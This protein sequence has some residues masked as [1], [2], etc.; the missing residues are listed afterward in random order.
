[1]LNRPWWVGT[2]V[3]PAGASK[4]RRGPGV[5]SSLPVR[6]APVAR[7]ATALLPV[8]LALGGCGRSPVDW[9]DLADELEL[10]P[11][12]PV[13]GGCRKVDFLFVIDDSASMA[14]NQRRLVESFDV[15][16]AGVMRSEEALGS[17]HVGVVTTDVY[18]PGPPECRA[19][20][21]LVTQTGGYNSSETQCGPYAEGHNYMTEQ[22]DLYETFPCAAQVGTTGN[23]LEHPL[24]AL[25]S[26][27]TKMQGPGEC[28]EG[29]IRD[30][31]LLVAVIVTDEDD[32]GPVAHRYEKL[33]DAKGGHEDNVVLVGLIN[34]PDTECQ[35][36]G[37]AS[38]G[39]WIDE[40]IGMFSHG[41]VAPVCGDYS[42]AFMQAVE[43]VEAACQDGG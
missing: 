36:G 3:T 28:N 12:D 42:Q 22:D 33:V 1:M 6:P 34:E 39:L 35:L 27:V 2:A 32:P 26:A 30:D 37:H 13:A 21:G 9:L 5:R 7:V 19:L 14:D 43:V 15:F 11:D 8:L 23:T 20:G 16:I 4:C 10:E 29:F 41:T 17:V 40:L 24:E 18:V 25:T 31:A 38:I